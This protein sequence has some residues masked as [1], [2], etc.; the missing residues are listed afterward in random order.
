MGTNTMRKQRGFTLIEIAIVLV[1]IGLLLGGVL[2]GQELITAARVRNLA[3]QI[4]GVKVAYFGFQDRFRSLPGDLL[5]G[6]ANAN[7]QGMP[8]G[9]A[10]GPT[11]GNGLIDVNE[12]FV[13]WNQLSKAGFITGSYTGT[14]ADVTPTPAINPTNPFGGYLQLVNDN[15]FD[16]ALEPAQP[17]ALNIKTGAQIPS[18]TLAELDRKID[19]GQPMSGTLRSLGNAA[20][21]LAPAG[22]APMVVVACNLAG[23]PVV[24][25]AAADLKNCGG[26]ALQ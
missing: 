1:I 16:D 7:I 22:G 14:V 9:C 25:N 5:A 23:P 4:D 18:G 6:T 26:V 12:M 2:K 11:C 8:G 3:S 21:T 10:L 24:W 17:I 15:I 20:R 13:A 19:D